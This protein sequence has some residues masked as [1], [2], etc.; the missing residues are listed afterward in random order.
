M[1]KILIV[2]LAVVLAFGAFFAYT[3]L[4]S[5]KKTVKTEEKPKPEQ[6]SFNYLLLGYGGG[7]HEGTYLTDTMILAHIDTKLKKVT[8]FSIPRDT[9]VRLPTKDREE[10]FHTK[11]NAVYQT[12]LFPEDYPGLDPK[13]LGTK[14]D[15]KLV[16]TIIAQIT[17][18]SIDGYVSVDFEGF[19]KAIDILEGIDVDVKRSFVD[20]E[21]PVEGKEKDL[22]DKDTEDLFKKAEPFI[23][24]G[25]NPE[26]R[27]RQF[28][29]NPKLEEFIKNA[30]SSPE[31][32]FPCRY[33]RLE[34]T[35]GITHMD[36]KTALKYARSRHSNQDGGDF[37]RAL[38]QQQVI[39][40]V[41]NKV[42]SLGIVTKILPLIEQYKKDVKTDIGLS[43]IQKFIGQA[44]D[45]NK[46]KINTYV[47]SD[48]NV[49]ENAVSD[50]KQYILI[51]KEGMDKWKETTITMDNVIRGITP[52]PEATPSSTIER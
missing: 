5:G 37:N 39:E 12:E 48:D 47:L 33:E 35:K 42:I 6:T 36:G 38:R 4:T 16:K 51:P 40:A 22:C 24:P 41:K 7:T 28:K 34:F 30:T 52:T 13:S 11:I 26:E 46:Y 9:W 44:D 10:V 3:K 25:F 17:G 49:L 20:S 15:A 19:T 32:A 50:D 1:K 29:E 8:L 31:L 27:D 43:V 45:V 23:T 18:L 14:D 2:V 21:Y